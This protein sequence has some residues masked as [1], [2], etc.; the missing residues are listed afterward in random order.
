ML[1]K[2]I[3]L[4]LASGPLI[5]GVATSSS[6]MTP[7]EC[8]TRYSAVDT[9]KQGYVTEKEAPAYFAI[10]RVANTVISDGKLSKD[11]FLKDCSSGIYDV[12]A[13]EKDAPLAGANSFTEGQAKDRILAHGGA[14]VSQLKKDEKGVWR[15]TAKFNNTQQNV[16]VDYKGNVVFTQ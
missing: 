9:A 8:E 5:I 7:V 10:Y 3:T 4:L 14:D 2:Y 11:T 12:A 15:G 13:N 16:A 6:A 1:N